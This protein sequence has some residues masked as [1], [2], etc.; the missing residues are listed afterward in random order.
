MLRK[1]V[2]TEFNAKARDRARCVLLALD[3]LTAPQIARRIDRSRRFVQRCCYAYRGHGLAGP[4]IKPRSGRPPNPSAR[5]QQAYKQ[6]VRDGPTP[7]YGVCTLRGRDFQRIPEAE[8]GVAYS[9][10]GG[11]G[12]L[13]WLSLSVL[14]PCPGHRKTD[15]EAEKRWLADAIFLSKP[16][17]SSTPAEGSRSGSRT[18]PG[19]AS[20]DA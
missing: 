19:S 16:C 17:V 14:K 15:H 11:Y 12:L 2:R 1:R 8:L 6:R 20:R 4:E 13:R 5:E 10:N 18:K 3:G 7:K 9:L